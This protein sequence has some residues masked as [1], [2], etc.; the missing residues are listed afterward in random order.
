[1]DVITGICDRMLVLSYGEVIDSGI[2]AEVV[3]DPRVIKAYLGGAHV[4]A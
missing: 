4:A 2:P 1:M 3:A